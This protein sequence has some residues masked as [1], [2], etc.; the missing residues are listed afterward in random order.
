M[1]WSVAVSALQAAR[2]RLPTVSGLPCSR[3]SEQLALAACLT[4]PMRLVLGERV[5]APNQMATLTGLDWALPRM[6]DAFLPCRV[7]GVL[8]V[9]QF[10]I[11]DVIAR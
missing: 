7:T 11:L 8:P 2:S 10:A 6:A 3:G 9:W 4:L 1:P 5:P